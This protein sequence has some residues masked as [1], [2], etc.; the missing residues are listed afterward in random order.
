MIGTSGHFAPV[1][2]ASCLRQIGARTFMTIDSLGRI[3]LDWEG[4]CSGSG[5]KMELSKLENETE[6]ATTDYRLHPN[7]ISGN[8]EARIKLMKG[9]DGVVEIFDFLGVKVAAYSVS[10]GENTLSLNHF[11]RNGLFIYHVTVNGKLKTT[12]KLV[13]LD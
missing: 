2:F 1:C 6:V 13:F 5:Y 11:Y 9:E 3:G 4:N 10:E 7:L 8:A 12:D